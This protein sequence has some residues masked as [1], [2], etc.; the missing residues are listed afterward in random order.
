MKTQEQNTKEVMA[1]LDKSA[2]NFFQSEDGQHWQAVVK[3][4]ALDKYV[5]IK[6]GEV[7]EFN[8]DHYLGAGI[9]AGK[10]FL[11]Q[12][13]HPQWN[14]ST[15]SWSR[16]YG[17]GPAKKMRA[18]RWNKARLELTSTAA[19]NYLAVQTEKGSV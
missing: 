3:L 6:D 5:F 17:H 9:T 7:H 2:Q 1:Y 19:Q 12:K 11:K 10:T 8:M 16:G 14:P 13:L 18:V 4:H 15:G